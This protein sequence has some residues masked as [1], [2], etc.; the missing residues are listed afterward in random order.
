M[1]KDEILSRWSEYIG[2]LYHDD[3]RGDMP[4]IAAEVESLGEK[5]STHYGASQRRNHLDQMV[6]LPR[7]L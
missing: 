3:N 6:S 7:C 5:L 2:E 1:E 4:D